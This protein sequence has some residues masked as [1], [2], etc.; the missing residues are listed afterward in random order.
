MANRGMGSIS[1]AQQAEARAQTQGAKELETRMMAEAMQPKGQPADIISLRNRVV[2]GFIDDRKDNLLPGKVKHPVDPGPDGRRAQ[3]DMGNGVFVNI[4]NE[5]EYRA[6]LQELETAKTQ[7]FETIAEWAPI[8][9]EAA[10]GRAYWAD[11]L[12]PGQAL[13]NNVLRD[14]LIEIR[15]GTVSDK[16][17]RPMPLVA[18]QQR[19]PDDEIEMITPPI[20]MP[21]LQETIEGVEDVSSLELPEGDVVNTA[22]LLG[23]IAEENAND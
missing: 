15:G 18:G 13:I 21:T 3:I 12:G 17:T 14:T 2:N 5:A 9:Q 22:E 4:P 19:A 11:P 8:F 10:K 1:P 16:P 23:K 7:M 20:P 6:G